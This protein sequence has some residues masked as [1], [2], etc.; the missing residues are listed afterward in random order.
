MKI[1]LGYNGSSSSEAAIELV[2]YYAK[3]FNANVFVATSVTQS[4][5]IGL[6]D[7]RKM[8]NAEKKLDGIKARF[9]SAGITCGTR[10]LVSSLSAGEN[11]IQYAE[12]KKV[13]LI[14]IGINKRSKVGKFL[15]GS[16]AQFVIL[17]AKC[18]VMSIK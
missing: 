5:E 11:L 6:Q 7:V 4:K 14:V 16:T 8:E 2:K 9:K 13:E 10:L 12:E 3:A 1:L 15:L 17:E 18:P